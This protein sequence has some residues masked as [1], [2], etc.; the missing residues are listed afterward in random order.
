LASDIEFVE[1]FPAR[2]DS[3]AMRHHRWARGDW[4][5][6]PWILG[7]E[8]TQTPRSSRTGTPLSGRWKMLDNLR[9]S[10]SAPAAALALLAGFASP[11]GASLIW[12]AFILATLALPPLIPLIGSLTQRSRT[13]VLRY[14]LRTLRS[15]VRMALAQWFLAVTFLAH[16]AWLMG[17]AAIRTLFRLASGRNLLEWTP[18]AHAMLG[19]RPT[20][21][22]YY[23]YMGGAVALAAAAALIGVS[24][25]QI[26]PSAL[27]LALLWGASPAIAVWVSKPPR[28]RKNSLL[29]PSDATA[30][31]L[32]ARRTWRYFETFVTPAHNALPP[33]NFQESPE[34]IVANRTS[35]TN[36]GLYL[37]SII[38]ARALGW[39]DSSNTAAR[40]EATHAT[41]QKLE[42]F[43]GHFYNWYDT[44]D[45]RALDPR[46]VSSVDSGNLA[47]HLVALSRAC[48]QWSSRAQQLGA[49]CFDAD[50]LAI[51]REEA[52]ALRE[53]RR[54]PAIPWPQIET[55]IDRLESM[56]RALPC[57]RED[58]SGRLGELTA[59]TDTLID[60]L[61]AHALSEG[62]DSSSELLYWLGAASKSLTGH[63]NPLDPA[64]T[65][66]LG[67]RF[68]T[69]ARAFRTMALAMD[70][71]F[72][73]NRDRLLLSIG[74]R[75]ADGVLDPS[76]YDLLASEARLASLLAIAKGD[77]PNKHWFRLSHA[78]VPLP[79]GPALI[80]WSGSM[81]EYLMPSLVMREPVHSVLERTNRFVVDRQIEY[82]RKLKVPWGVSESAYN[83]RDLDFTYQYSNFGVPGLGLKRGLADN[84]VISPYATALAAMVS[85]TAAAR[86][87]EHLATLGAR[88]RYG[89]CEAIDFTPERLQSGQRCAVVRCFMAHH[90]GMTITALTN[91][92]CAGLLRDLFHSEPIIQASE[93]LL[94][95]RMP[96]DIQTPPALAAAHQPVSVPTDQIEPTPQRRSA[97]PWATTPATH[98]LSNGNYSV[99]LTAAGS[100]YS[101]WRG[102]AVTRW[103]E[104]STQ[105]DWGSYFY[106]K[107]TESGACL[108]PSLQPA[109]EREHEHQAVFDEEVAVFTSA[110]HGLAVT[111]EVIVSSEDDAE[112]R[113]LSITNSGRDV[114]A[115]EITSFAELALAP[116]TADLA[117]P[118]FSKL[119][120]EVEHLPRS[121]AL[122]AR[123]RKRAPE[124]QEVW[125]A[126]LAIV[127]GAEGGQQEFETSRARFIGRGRDAHEPIAVLSGS[128][129]SGTVGATLDPI[130]ALRR[131]IRVEPGKTARVHFW[132]MAAASRR[133]ALDIID[134][135]HDIAAYD[136]AATLAWTQSQVELHHI[137]IDRDTAALYQRLA[138][139]LIYA[140]PAMRPSSDTIRSGSGEQSLLWS[141]GVSG[142]LPIL[143]V[144]VSEIGETRLVREALQA[145][146]YLRSKRLALDLVIL[147]ERDASYQ[148]ELQDALENAVRATQSRPHIGAEPPAGHIYVLR[149][150]LIT[151][152]ARALLTSVARVVLR[153]ER[154]RL[155]DQLH[156]RPETEHNGLR[157]RRP[158]SM[159]VLQPPGHAPELEYFNGLGGFAKG[160]NEYVITLAPGQSTPAPW[161][162]VVAN[163]SFG[164]Q[165][166]ESGAGFTWS[167]SSREHQITPWSNDPVSDSPGQAF[168]LRDRDSGETWSP[169]AA[170]IRDAAATYVTR[171]GRG[172][173]SFACEV[174]GVSLGLTEFVPLSDPIKIS[175]LTIANTSSVR[176]RLSVTGYVAWVL[177][178]S[179]TAAAPLVTT[180]L[181]PVT[182]A[183]L[184][185]NFWNP[186]FKYRVAFADLC[187]RQQSWTGDRR[188]FIGRNGSMS[189]PAALARDAPLSG[190]LGAGL[191]PCAALQTNLEL[192]PGESIELVF[193]LGDAA[194][195]EEA[196]ALVAR[197]READLDGVL[198]D[199]GA[200]GGRPHAPG[201]PRQPFP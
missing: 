85:P 165:T 18:A 129:L 70:F 170:P 120:V 190:N 134:K 55:E 5:L 34:P 74:Y 131:R 125:A 188:E 97:D 28:P 137:G 21:F 45:L 147:N 132:T 86:N 46:Y 27:V 104:D 71:S 163:A 89:F 118:A 10:M 35:P 143:L 164:F 52:H 79:R 184:A 140:T 26:E 176:R 185:S 96:R 32:I 6:L 153:G 67:A 162:N 95:E 66:I 107:D 101:T 41:L 136:R 31:R 113:R 98:L 135:H 30:L 42:R 8:R 78:V 121:G 173:S 130:F 93:L 111:L 146:E 15:D 158:F 116:A 102:L 127:E 112:V 148:Q 160:G 171:H 39:I 51:A 54:T 174:S 114:R 23:R 167:E 68:D 177:G 62:D 122:L 149:A 200:F 14:R 182:G 192:G 152:E 109:C 196:R 126:H 142:D 12:T 115:L 73:V 133:E 197:Y 2:Y 84:V 82:G 53:K 57:D 87:F 175:R 56:M 7:L 187:G 59:A 139:H 65:E 38:S 47:G 180:Q 83:A 60:T 155:A 161:I 64:A 24:R 61:E 103:R 119:F 199:V 48:Q 13:N 22:S 138:G 191:D 154:G 110:A 44:H 99:M 72:L 106:I 17:D 36:I 178:A 19:E 16:Q 194:N 29:A 20:L 151:T 63:A 168:F 80:S 181:C 144:H 76:C 179:R 124:E 157:G 77:A 195:D 159:S 90:Q 193:L 4:Q 141:L 108:T 33:D 105:D 40:L 117:H 156:R 43:R 75:G 49:S 172:Y 145:F 92:L 81:F 50:A 100:G 88:G 91:V 128:P 3:A 186:A 94:Q 201:S 198:S 189:N 1:T 25:A 150:D 69:L 58:R 169:T 183:I 166:S 11:P 9:R 37:L 123:R